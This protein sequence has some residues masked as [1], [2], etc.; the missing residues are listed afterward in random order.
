MNLKKTQHVLIECR[1]EEIPNIGVEKNTY[2]IVNGK[3]LRSIKH[4]EKE[5]TI[6]IYSNKKKL[7]MTYYG[8]LERERDIA[9]PVEVFGK[10]TKIKRVRRFICYKI[11]DR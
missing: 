6:F 8:S 2:I 3:Y 5:Y 9:Q 4:S 7:S 1:L 11:Q 10:I